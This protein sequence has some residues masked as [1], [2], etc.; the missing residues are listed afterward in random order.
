MTN[1]KK[2]VVKQKLPNA[3][4]A[5]SGSKTQNQSSGSNR[6]YLLQLFVFTFIIYGNTL[7]NDYALDDGIVIT[8]N[9]F[10]QKGFAGIADILT[11]DSFSGW[12]KNANSDVA[13]GRYRPLSLVSF[14]IE[15]S[16]FGNNPRA[17]HLINVLL[18]A[19]I[20]IVIFIFLKRLL[21]DEPTKYSYLSHLPFLTALIFITHPI[22]TEAVANIKGRDEI[23]S[24]LFSIIASIYF[25]KFIDD[26]KKIKSIIFGSLFLFLGLLS[27]EN[28]ITFFLIIPLMLFFFRNGN[29]KTILP[30]LVSIIISTGI[31]LFLRQTFSNTSINKEVTDLMNNPFFGMSASQKYAT[32]IYTF[33]KYLWLLILPLHLTSDYY[34][35]QISIHEFSSIGTILSLV[36]CM[37][38]VVTAFIQLSKK[39]IFSFSVIYFA[40]T[41]SVV[42]N[43]VFPVGTFMSERFLFMPSLAFCLLFAY[44][45]NLIPYY[46]FNSFPFSKSEISPKIIAADF[47]G[48]RN[49]QI[50]LILI[51]GAYSIK[52][53]ARNTDWKNNFTLFSAAVIN[54]PNSAMSHHAIASEL[55]KKGESSINKK[56]Q[57]DYYK[58]SIA[59]DEQSI[60]IHPEF[61]QAYYNIGVTYLL[62]EDVSAAEKSFR[63][64]ISIAPNYADALNNLGHCFMRENKLDSAIILST[65]ASKIDTTYFRPYSTLGAIYLKKMDLEKSH[66]FFYMANKLEPNDATSKKMLDDLNEIIRSSN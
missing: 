29:I 39:T 40:V 65:S 36:I 55:R 53:I 62:M 1:K 15:H 52:T 32:I 18:Y 11:H 20:G 54:S 47:F 57:L 60:T 38:L 64:T 37:V 46:K 23:L 30:V 45:I 25:L 14:A 59:A 49:I 4:T 56:V 10:V 31:Y 2:E 21:I 35:Y 61:A 58:Q 8:Q 13:G 28:A 6:Y 7:W 48:M 3:N 17:S 50:I 26:G 16:M 5:K 9:Q 22:H 33:G 24:L 34:P 12:Q 66:Y 27:K 41:L 43:L 44:F 51:C 19:I 42:S 63:K